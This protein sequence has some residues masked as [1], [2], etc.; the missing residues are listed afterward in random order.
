MSDRATT[1]EWLSLTCSSWRLVSVLTFFT[2]AVEFRYLAMTIN[3][4]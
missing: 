3:A 1:L 2:A 4:S